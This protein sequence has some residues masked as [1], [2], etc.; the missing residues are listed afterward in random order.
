MVKR[1]KKNDEKL[2]KEENDRERQFIHHRN[3]KQKKIFIEQ[4]EDLRES[5]IINLILL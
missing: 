1:E 3:L 5:S 4:D 2:I